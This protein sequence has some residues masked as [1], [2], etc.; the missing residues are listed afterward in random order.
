MELPYLRPTDTGHPPL[1]NKDGLT[2]C[3]GSYLLR[4]YGFTS[5]CRNRPCASYRLEMLSHMVSTRAPRTARYFNPYCIHIRKRI[6]RKDGA[7]RSN[8]PVLSHV[9][10]CGLDGW[11]PVQSRLGGF[12]ALKKTPEAPYTTKVNYRYFTLA[13]RSV[14]RDSWTYPVAQAC[15]RVKL[16]AAWK[17]LAETHGR[18]TALQTAD[19]TS[20][21]AQQSTRGSS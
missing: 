14:T 21:E 13:H 15:A 9:W 1:A 18:P 17:V 4:L 10:L 19:R 16:Y 7:C 12:R 2:Y 8:D 11:S 5:R 6:P 3:S 20:R